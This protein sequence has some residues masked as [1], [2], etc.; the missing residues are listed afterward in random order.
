M[1]YLIMHNKA[2]T[3]IELLVVIAIIGILAG[4]IIVSMSG[5]SSSANDSRRKADINQLSKAIMIHK[6]N[7]PDALLPTSSGCSIGTDCPNEVMEALGSANVLRDPDSTRYYSYSSDGQDYVISSL[8]S[9]EDNYFF[10]S[11][12][13]TY[14]TSS[15]N[16]PIPGN[17][18]C[19]VA[20]GSSYYEVPPSGDLCT[21]GTAG[22]VTGAGPWTW[23]CVGISTVNCSANKKIDGECG[24]AN[25]KTYSFLDNEYGEDTICD[26][27]MPEVIPGFPDSGETVNWSCSSQYDGMTESCSATRVGLLGYN[28]RKPVTIT[29]SSLLNNHQVKLAVA[30]DADMQPDF[31]DLRFTAADEQTL[32]DYWI[33]SKINSVSAVVWVDLPVLQVGSNS[34]Y[35]YYG[36]S[37]VVTASNGYD[38][39]EFFDGFDGDALDTSKWTYGGT[40][41][42][43]NGLINVYGSTAVTTKRTFDT[44]YIIRSRVMGAHADKTTHVERILWNAASGYACPLFSWNWAAG[45]TFFTMDGSQAEYT[46]MGLTA[47]AYNILEMVRIGT[48]AIKLNIDDSRTITH[49]TRIPLGAGTFAINTGNDESQVSVDWVTLRKYVAIEPSYSF[50]AEQ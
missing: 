25:G 41:S 35:M 6:T 5:A 30:Y 22:I 50:G 34:A 27:G 3:L 20:N 7:H 8:L 28:K 44:N 38:T 13:G 43:V 19:G 37:S 14:S 4:F 12:T 26:V 39:F 48:S 36:N 2:F 47:G 32:L 40:Y 46:E 1:K 11:S 23:D 31:D 16:P 10:D 17:G 24:T 29:S 18:V 45:Q 42:V 15:S 33:E 9:T 21:I 49:T